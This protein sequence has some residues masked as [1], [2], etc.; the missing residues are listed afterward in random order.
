[1]NHSEILLE[2]GTNQ[3]AFTKFDLEKA[4][5]SE[6]ETAIS[7][8]SNMEATFPLKFDY[9]A[10]KM[11]DSLQKLT[12]AHSS[13]NYMEQNHADTELVEIPKSRDTSQLI[14]SKNPS[15]RN[16][17][18]NILKA[19]NSLSMSLTSINT[20]SIL[21]LTRPGDRNIDVNKRSTYMIHGDEVPKV[22]SD[23]MMHESVI[24]RST[25]LTRDLKY[26]RTDDDLHSMSMD[27]KSSSSQSN[28]TAVHADSDVV[29]G[30]GEKRGKVTSTRFPSRKTLDKLEGQEY[31]R[32][33]INSVN[34]I[35]K[36]VYN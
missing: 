30:A 6:L 13:N 12:A 34:S 17:D 11:E 16:D 29:K 14:V 5:L 15:K 20:A 27:L 25:Y 18:A 32:P 24:K 1:M 31:A 9:N 19:D 36:F 35:V 33:V 28:W 10:S 26:D 4:I 21:E 23:S 2:T 3:V 8:Q 22:H 7:E